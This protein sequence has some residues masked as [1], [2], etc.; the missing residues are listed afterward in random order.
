MISTTMDISDID[1]ATA[2]IIIEL[3]ITDITEDLANVDLEKDQHETFAVL[4]T[5]L[6]YQLENLAEEVSERMR[7]ILSATSAC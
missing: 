2:C 6:R 5:A 3:R 7:N 4:R 1:T